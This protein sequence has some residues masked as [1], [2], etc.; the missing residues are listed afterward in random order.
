[1]PSKRCGCQRCLAEYPPD[2]HGERNPRRDCTGSWQSRYR[3]AD[4]EQK[5]RNFKIKDGG[6]KAAEAFL[7]QVRTEVR[8]GTYLD[9]KRGQITIE[10]W[11]SLWWPSQEKKGHTTTRNRKAS[12]WTAHVRPKWGRRKIAS[13]TYMEIQS[14][15]T[16]EVLGRATQE[17]CLQLLRAMLRDAVRD[18]RIPFNPAQDVEVT[19]AATKRHPDAL[20][21]PTPAQYQLVRELVPSWYRPLLDFAEETGMRWGE[22]TGLRRCCVDL[23]GGYAQVRE[24]IVDD[25]GRLLRQAM[26]KT[27]AGVRTVPL[28]GKAADAARTMIDRLDPAATESDVEGGMHPE[29]LIFRGPM[30]GEKRKVKGSAV[31]LD[32]VLNRNNFRRI[33]IPAI[34]GAGIARMVVN[35]E[36]KR[37]EWWPRVHDYRHALASR[38]HAAGVPE[39]DVQYVLGQER[40]GRVTWLY[41]HVSDDA[42]ATVRAAMETGRALRAVS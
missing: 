34:K 8:K 20:K 31:V 28:T 1:M 3:D 24:I 27:D 32:G 37:R 30:T 16:R 35:P 29:E 6:K 11:W 7:D 14:W 10:K 9:P 41:T 36:T 13:L 33:W 4:G 2:L 15:I 17:K 40:G 42:L 18:Q 19:A 25:H 39:R 5:S 26:P 23:D 21:P 12:S 38:L 22:Y